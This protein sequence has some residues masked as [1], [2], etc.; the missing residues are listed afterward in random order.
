[1]TRH[2][3]NACCRGGMD[4]IRSF[5]G[6]DQGHRMRYAVSIDPI[7]LGCKPCAERTDRFTGRPGRSV[8]YSARSHGRSGRNRTATIA[9]TVDAIASNTD[10]IAA[11][12]SSFASTRLIRFVRDIFSGSFGFIS[13]LDRDKGKQMDPR[14]KGQLKR[15]IR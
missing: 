6:R 10:A 14:E 12:C 4:R 11:T 8:T 7:Q 9:F 2:R 15:S 13:W 1:M 3:K 5:T